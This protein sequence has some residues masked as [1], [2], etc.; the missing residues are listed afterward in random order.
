MAKLVVEPLFYI[1]FVYGM[2]FLLMSYMVF[3]GAM[4]ASDSPLVFSFYL[5]AL[6]GLTHGITEMT[7]WVRF[8]V[9]TL[10]VEEIKTLTYLSQTFLVI[11]FAILFQFGSNLLAYQSDNRKTFM[12]IPSILVAFF[13]VIILS[14]GITDVLK[15]G[16]Y[17]RYS[18]GF[19]GS[20][21]SAIA[22]TMMGNTV[23]LLGDQ[24]LTRGLTIAAAG[25]TCYAVF[26]GL[27][28]KPIAGVPIQLF[29]AACAVAVAFSSF[30]V[31]DVF[32]Y[33]KSK[34]EMA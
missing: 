12:A 15:I 14:L 21:L 18:F 31:I 20:V 32:K 33:V 8:M 17:A 16:L 30:A 24:K 19:M 9:K 23:K 27:I 6:F 5:L 13:I 1:F 2:S 4:K 10:G 25:F 22:L 3:R 7:D 29:R 26:G 34:V 28:I 11:S